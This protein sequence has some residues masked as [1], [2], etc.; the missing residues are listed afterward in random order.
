[1]EEIRAVSVDSPGTEFLVT[2]YGFRD[3]LLVQA[4]Y[5]HTF[6]AFLCA[7]T[8]ATRQNQGGF[9]P[10]PGDLLYA[11]V[12]Q[13]DW[14]FA[15][16]WNVAWPPHV[17]PLTQVGRGAVLNWQTLAVITEDVAH[18]FTAAITSPY[19]QYPARPA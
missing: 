11:A 6:R 2:H 7:W 5:Q 16:R 9:G 4:D 8:D 12:G 15:A 17:T 19:V 13:V 18:P 1:G 3:A 14:G 10:G